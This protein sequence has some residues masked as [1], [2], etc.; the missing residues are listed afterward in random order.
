MKKNLLFLFLS[1]LGFSLKGQIV[2]SSNTTWV[3]NQ[4]LTQ[5]VVVQQGV[6]LTINPGV[7]VQVLF[8]DNNSDLIGDVKIEIKGSL[9]VLGDAC[10]KVKFVPYVVTSNKQYWSGI[11]LDTLATNSSIA[12][13]SIQNANI[14]IKIENTSATINGVEILNSKVNGIYA[15]GSNANVA[16]NNSLIKSCDGEGLNITNASVLNINNSKVKLNGSSGLNVISVQ[17]VTIANSVVYNNGKSGIFLNSSIVTISNSVI[18]KNTRMGVIVSSTNLTCNTSDIDSNSVDGMFVG[19]SSIL[20]MSNSTLS[21]NVGFGIE[22]SEYI[23]NSD[24]E[25]IAFTASSP[26]INISSTNFINN[27]NT[28]V[29]ISSSQITN[30]VPAGHYFIGSSASICSEINPTSGCYIASSIQWDEDCNNQSLTPT[31]VSAWYTYTTFHIPF[32]LFAGFNGIIGINSTN[33][34][35]QD[36]PKYGISN[37]ASPQAPFWEWSYNATNGNNSLASYYSN[38]YPINVG[39]FTLS[40]KIGFM[41][42]VGGNLAAANPAFSTNS[43]AK[44]AVSE[45]YFKFGGYNYRS[46]INSSSITDVLTGNYWDTI[47]PAAVTNSVGAVLNLNGFVISEIISAHSNLSNPFIYSIASTF[48][49]QQSSVTFCSGGGNY[50]IAPSGNYTYQWYDNDS[51][52]SNSNDSLIV[53]NTGNYSVSLSGTCAALSSPIAVTVYLTP[54]TPTISSSE[55]TTFCSGGSVTLTSSSATGNTWSNGATTQAITVSQSGNY[56]VTVANGNCSATSSPIAVTVNAAPSIPTISAGGATTFCSGGSVTLTSSSASSNTW[57]N[58]ATTQAITVSQS[59]NYTVSVSNG[60]CSA[61]SSPLA[62]TVNTV[63]ATP[64]ISAGGATTFCSGGSVTLTSSSASG[65][66][67]SNDA[68]TQAIAISQSGNYT[69]TVANGNCSATSSPIAVTVNAVP[70]TP[71]ISASGPTTF[72]TGESVTLTSSSALGNTWSNGATTQAIIVS[73][74][75]NYTVSLSNGTCTATSSALTVTV[76]TV[77]ATPTISAGGSTT[78]C[79]GGSVT[80]TSSSASGNTWSNGE[81]TQAITVSQSGNYTVTV[82]NGNCSATSS[83]IAVTVNAAPST[84]TISASGPTTFCSGGSVTLTSS[85]AIGNTWSNGATTQSITVSNNGNYSVTITG[86]NGC[87]VSS[88]ALS[89]NVNQSPPIPVITASGPTTFCQGGSVTLTSPGTVGIVW[90][91][92]SNQYT[93]DTLIVANNYNNIYITSTLNGCNSQSAFLNV[94]VNQLPNAIITSSGPTTFCSGSSVSLTSNQASSYLWSNGATA[95]AINPNTSGSYS[96]TVTDVNGCTKTSSPT[97][98]T[99]KPMP[100]TAVSINGSQ[101]IANQSS[102]V[103]QWLDCLNNN[104][105]IFGAT[106]SSYSPN[107]SGTYAVSVSLNGCSDTS[108]CYAV[109][110][111]SSLVEEEEKA[112]LSIHPNPTMDYFILTVPNEFIGRSYT[113][114]DARG[115]LITEGV[116]NGSEETLEVSKL[117]TGTYHLKIDQVSERYKLIKQ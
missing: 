110:V 86:L 30:M 23:F 3:T 82:A 72:C 18:R 88:T 2:I 111:T 68:T 78:F 100:S 107:Q 55:P 115:R 1:L 15:F 87:S 13:A 113:L 7:Q 8:I 27:Q 20:T 32:G 41:A 85:S 94:T 43:F 112:F 17:N 12:N 83:P 57:S 66:T 101:L 108:S 10:N 28:S 22:T 65:N 14:G 117:E 90:H 42:A 26:S 75:G 37:V 9:N 79:S 80:L 67:W 69:V 103:Y 97:I 24:F 76:N 62:V 92:G 45:F 61:T 109:T 50:L 6:T 19:G 21:D 74:A 47:V 44:Y 105:S 95:Q 96:V 11:E 77:P 38:C 98:V 35:Y 36:R 56:T 63:P 102:A 49:L 48:E 104:I 39:T 53:S 84:P 60:A 99:V 70:S 51:P 64:T 16:V 46:L 5:S 33:N 59:G 91:V 89:V 34:A 54:I 58:G 73:Q 71:T 40:D 52:I 81:T 93:V 106:A 29:I 4:V 31:P 114:L 116:L 25:N